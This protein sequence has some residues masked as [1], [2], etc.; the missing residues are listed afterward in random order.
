M[1]W[2]TEHPTKAGFYWYRDDNRAVVL[3]VRDSLVKEKMLAWDWQNGRLSQIRLAKY[4][5]R[6][7]AQRSS[8][9]RPLLSGFRAGVSN[10]DPCEVGASLNFFSSRK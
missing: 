10:P 2:T 4:L 3:E 9:C 7:E 6:L 8:V 5:F 1:K